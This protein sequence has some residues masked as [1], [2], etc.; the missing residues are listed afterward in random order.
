MHLSIETS[1]A[2]K[3]LSSLK[4]DKKVTTFYLGILDL[5]ADMKLPQS[6]I[7]VDNP[8]V[9][10]ILSHFL[11]TCKS[12]GV[13]PVSFVYQEFKN[14]DMFEKW[15][16]LEKAI[17]Y[18]AK[19][20]ISPTQAKLVNE[21]FV[22]EERE[23]ERAKNIIKLFELNKELYV[24]GFEDEEFGFIDEPI[25]KGALVLLERNTSK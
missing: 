6:L 14:L 15:I 3:N 21:K 19:G 4:I 23:I 2:W 20:C 25:Y 9:L 5:F 17:G 10:Y 18:D 12:I 7:N 22:D 11:I 8:T 1:G 24:T 16:S 13:K